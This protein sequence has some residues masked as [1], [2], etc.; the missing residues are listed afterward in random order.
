MAEERL[1]R[2]L[3][4]AFDPGPDSPSHAWLSRTMAAVDEKSGLD[5]LRTGISWGAIRP[6][7]SV[8]AA[9]ILVALA[10]V[11]TGAFIAINEYAHRAVL[12]HPEPFKVKAPGAAVCFTGCQVNSAVFVSPSVGFLVE[13]TAV[14][15]CTAT[16]P[17]QTT[18]L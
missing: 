15:A 8:V 18:V 10:V 9:L 17:Q 1:K 7:R 5:K 11:T 2:N 16:C 12:V 14:T 4:L 6:G 3:D 13:A